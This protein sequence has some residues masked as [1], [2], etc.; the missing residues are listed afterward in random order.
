M[1]KGADA[2]TQK[3]KEEA[4]KKDSEPLAAST[5][6]EE[7]RPLMSKHIKAVAPLYSIYH[8]TLRDLAADHKLVVEEALS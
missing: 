6:R 8:A 5:L 3:R 1:K 7:G 2:V 4:F